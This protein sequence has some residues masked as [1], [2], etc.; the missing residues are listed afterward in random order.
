MPEEKE[1]KKKKREE[2][3]RQ[4]NSKLNYPIFFHG[5]MTKLFQILR[6]TSKL[7]LFC[8]LLLST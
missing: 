8:D 6:P 7:N 2:E 1:I 4:I 5:K 3:I